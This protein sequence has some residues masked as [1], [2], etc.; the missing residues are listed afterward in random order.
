MTLNSKLS[1][2]LLQAELPYEMMVKGGTINI[3]SKYEL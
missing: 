1:A 3:L 2:L